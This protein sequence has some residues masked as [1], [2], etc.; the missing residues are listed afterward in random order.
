MALLQ[1]RVDDDLACQAREVARSMG[2]DLSFAVRLFLR[3]MVAE[4]GLP[5]RPSCDPFSSQS[6]VEALKRSLA[7]PEAGNV[8]SPKFPDMKHST[9]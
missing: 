7:Q 4:N 8:V 2:L 5:F 1:I 3:Q 6:N 9:R